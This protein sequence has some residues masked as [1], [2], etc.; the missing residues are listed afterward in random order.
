[1]NS[2]IF[3]KKKNGWNKTKQAEKPYFHCGLQAEKLNKST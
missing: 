2:T 1:M 3:L